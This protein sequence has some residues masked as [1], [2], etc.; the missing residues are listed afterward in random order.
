M[1]LLLKS[2]NV[3]SDKKLMQEGE[4]KT[5]RSAYPHTGS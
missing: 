5:Y 3:A 2:P 1:R 4:V